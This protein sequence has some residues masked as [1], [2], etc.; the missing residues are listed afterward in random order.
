MKFAVKLVEAG[1]AWP[2]SLSIYCTEYV[3]KGNK[4]LN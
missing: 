1:M 2:N 3:S 4:E